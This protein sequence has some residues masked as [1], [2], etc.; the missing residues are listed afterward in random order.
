MKKTVLFFSR[1]DLVHLYGPLGKYLSSDLNIVHVAYSKLEADILRNEYG[2]DSVITF[3]EIY[4]EKLS[5]DSHPA[6]FKMLDELFINNSNG[7]FSLNSSIK[8]DRTLKKLKYSETLKISSAYYHAWDEIF[9][10]SKIDF[11]IH[12]PTSLMINHMAAMLCRQKGAVYSTHIMVQGEDKY[13]FIMLDHDSGYPTELKSVYDKITPEDIA[14]EKERIEK[15]LLSF[16]AAYDVFFSIIE[17]KKPG[18][19]F[20]LKLF[21]R[22]LKEGIISKRSKKLDPLSENIEVFLSNDRLNS[23]RLKNFLDYRRV[24]YDEYNPE[25]SFYFYPLHLEPEAV[26]LYWA[27]GIYTNQVKLIENIA[28]QLPVGTF[29][30]VKDHPHL[31]GYRDVR[32]YDIIKDIPN[33]KL[34]PPHMPGKKIVKDSKGVITLNGTAG[35]EALLLNKKIITFGSAFYQVSDR[36]KFVKNIKDLREVLYTM[37][38]GDFND[39]Y[40]LDR[41]VLAYLRSLKVGFTDFYI[42]LADQIDLDKDKNLRNAASGL[43]AFF[44]NYPKSV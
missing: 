40:D 12:E 23:R 7:R 44:I 19:S 6:F 26:V 42:G 35:L 8:S 34:L 28:G 29:L 37:Q 33:V 11:F 27:D 32:D 18:L 1:C 13:N 36:V 39:D 3:K 16:R 31:Y 5:I 43:E 21:K 41:F 30:Y 2:I 25:D 38:D 20:Y 22:S 9:S 24:K 10:A 17:P 15:F 14:G 4:K